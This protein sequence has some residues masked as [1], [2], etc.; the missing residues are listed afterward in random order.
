MSHIQV[1]AIIAVLANVL[2]LLGV[3]VGSEALTTTLTTIVTIGAGLWIMVRR[4]KM[5]GIKLFGGRKA[6]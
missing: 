6:R 3:Q 5:G 1:S 4:Y 2:P